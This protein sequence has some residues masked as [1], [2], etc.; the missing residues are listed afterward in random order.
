MALSARSVV[1]APVSRRSAVKCSAA[2]T[3][4]SSTSQLKSAGGKQVVEVGGQKVLLLDV[5]GEISA[6]SN[7]CSHLGLP[8]QGKTALFTA[9][10]KDKCVICPAHGTAFDVKTGEV[11]GEWC[12][13]LPN[14]PLVGKGPG[15]KPLPVFQVRVS[16]S[17]D[18]EVNV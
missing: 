5:N 11:K 18:I 14:L 16:D 10:V 1:A 3:K 17:G 13:K 9:E 12:P 7:K 2:F 4:V 6:V 8:I 15:K